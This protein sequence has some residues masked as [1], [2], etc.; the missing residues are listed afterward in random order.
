LGSP[1]ETFFLS[2]VRGDIE[3]CASV[4][5]VETFPYAIYERQ[6]KQE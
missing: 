5:N 3:I 6:V 4:Y 2:G 1:D